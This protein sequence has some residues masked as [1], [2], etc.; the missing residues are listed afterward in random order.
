MVRRKRY[1]RIRRKK[2][3][4][5]RKGGLLFLLFLIVLGAALFQGYRWV[6]GELAA[7]AHLFMERVAAGDRDGAEAFLSDQNLTINNLMELFKEPGISYSGIGPVRLSG[8][9]GGRVEFLYKIGGNKLSAPLLLLRRGLQW[10][11]QE[12]PQI[13]TVTGA[14]VRGE[15]D[16]QL[17]LFWE[18]REKTV[19]LT[20]EIGLEFGSAVRVRLVEDTAVSVELLQEVVLSRLIRRSASEIEGEL[21]GLFPAAEALPVYKVDQNSVSAGKPGDL[22]IGREQLSFYLNAGEIVAAKVEGTFSPRTI[23]VVLRQNLTNL[24]AESLQHRWLRL[25][26]ETALLLEDRI[27]GVQYEFD[28]GRSLLVE[29]VDSG[30]RVTPAGEA[31]LTFTNRIWLTA[32]GSGRIEI[33]SLQRSGWE[34]ASPAYRGT[35]DISSKGDWLVVVNEPTLEQYLYTVVPSEMPISFGLEPLKAQAVAARTY[36]YNHFFSGRFSQYGAHVDDSVLS[37]VYHNIPEYP[38]SNEAV[39]ATAGMVLFFDEAVA[40]TRFFSTSSGYTANYHEVWQDAAGR[41]PADPF[42]YL[43]AASQIPGETVKLQTEAQVEAFLQ[44]QDWPAYDAEAPF[45]RWHVEMTAEE[46]AASLNHNLGPRYQ[47]QSDFI[48]TWD[49]D[50][51]RSIDIPRNPLG[52]LTDIRVARRGSGGNLM[53][54]D[55]EGTNGTY[56]I[57]KEYNIRFT[58]RPVQYLESAPPVVLARGD[59]SRLNDYAILPSAFV[60]FELEKDNTGRLEKVVIY[61]GGN[62][63]GVG[64]SQYGARGMA[65]QGHDFYAILRHFYPGSNIQ[66]IRF[67]EE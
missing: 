19:L 38:S 56:R 62:G 65:Q 23:R 60:C 54:L 32:A 24:S 36:A 18:G 61:G 35:L 21:E 51:F 42:P 17:K 26:G 63:H 5:T 14:F 13:V 41:F 4:S 53:E 43:Q 34:G 7:Q 20:Q 30:I 37:Q 12:V 49:G 58:L 64:M 9:V 57:I 59:G 3:K 40:D 27:S 45:F 39:E 33:S 46:L 22:T 1:R 55:V 52:T 25:S 50:G 15:K 28:A 11:V 2:R 48:L 16:R 67:E 6:T 66:N 29:P 31:A 10:H 47:E 44:R 8:L